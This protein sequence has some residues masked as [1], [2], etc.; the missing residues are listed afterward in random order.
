MKLVVFDALPNLHAVL[1]HF[2]IG[3]LGAA[4]AADLVALAARPGPRRFGITLLYLAGTVCLAVAYVAGRDAA[5]AVYTPGMA[6][7]AVGDHWSLALVVTLYFALVTLA[8]LGAEWL[9]SPRSWWTR[10]VFAAGGV[11]G[12]AGLLVVA[13]LGGQL[14]YR[15]GVG[16]AAR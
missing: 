3:L 9:V 13:D 5:P 2:P 15:W 10:A 4:V 8:R 12:L 6:H 14:V 11:A 16:V 1:V 7:A